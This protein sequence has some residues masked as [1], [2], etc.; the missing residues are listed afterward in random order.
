MENCRVVNWD[1]FTIEII[2]IN[3]ELRISR[4]G[5]SMIVATG[6]TSMGDCGAQFNAY[7]SDARQSN[8]ENLE[9]N[10]VGKRLQ[11]SVIDM[12]ADLGPSSTG[13]T[14]IVAHGAET[15]DVDLTWQLT[16][17]RKDQPAYRS[18]Y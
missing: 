10:L 12:K 6:T 13:K 17:W 3:V 14:T 4:T 16:F 7:R 5:R 8:S 2:D 18:W 1:P 15:E 9:W 11:V